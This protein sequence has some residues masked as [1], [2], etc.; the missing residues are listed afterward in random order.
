M[1]SGRARVAAFAIVAFFLGLFTQSFVQDTTTTSLPSSSSCPE[2]APCVPCPQCDETLSPQATAP[3]KVGAVTSPSTTT[4]SGTEVQLHWSHNVLRDAVQFQSMTVKSKCSDKRPPRWLLDHRGF[5]GYCDVF[6]EKQSTDFVHGSRRISQQPPIARGTTVVNYAQ[7]L[8]LCKLS[9][10]LCLAPQAG[11]DHAMIH[12]VNVVDQIIVAPESVAFRKTSLVTST[13]ERKLTSDMCIALDDKSGSSFDRK[14]SV[15]VVRLDGHHLTEAMP[16][17]AT[18]QHLQTRLGARGFDVFEL[19]LASCASVATCLASIR[20]I[21]GT[22]DLIVVEVPSN[23]GEQATW[24]SQQ[25]LIELLGGAD[26]MRSN[27][28]AIGGVVMINGYQ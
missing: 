5:A 8:V 21:G 16:S 2:V 18:S 13:A 12:Y 4:S 6:L 24:A 27:K 17:P 14:A 7:S 22:L 26:F 1:E 3:P 20:D 9:S 11:E 28:L 23:S 19:R 25:L 15:L 10:V